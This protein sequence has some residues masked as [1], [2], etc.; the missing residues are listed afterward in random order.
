VLV[1]ELPPR[2]DAVVE[3][4][5]RGQI[6]GRRRAAAMARLS[7]VEV[8][9]RRASAN[10]AGGDRELAPPAVPLPNRAPHMRG[11]T[12]GVC[13]RARL[14]SRLLYESVPPRVALEQQVDARLDDLG[15]PRAGE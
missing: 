3:A 1:P 6:L 9:A 12:L 10:A 15:E 5:A 4:A 13:G 11:D 14:L 8:D 2:L 7:V